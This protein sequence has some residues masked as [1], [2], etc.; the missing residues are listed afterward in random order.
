MGFNKCGGA[1]KK[2]GSKK[3]SERVEL[4]GQDEIAEKNW[5]VRVS[6]GEPRVNIFTFLC[7]TD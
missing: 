5:K 3:G 4:R 7:D 1:V 6:E 2:T